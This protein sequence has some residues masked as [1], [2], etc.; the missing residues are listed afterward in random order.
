MHAQYYR[1]STHL[2]QQDALGLQGK[3][4]GT[5]SSVKKI[6]QLQIQNATQNIALLPVDVH[7]KLTI[8][9]KRN[10]AS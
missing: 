4:Q 1:I 7:F 6:F 10:T 2:S 9:H 3:A 5:C 8:L